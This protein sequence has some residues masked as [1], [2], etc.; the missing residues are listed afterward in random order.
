MNAHSATSALMPTVSLDELA[1]I[2]RCTPQTMTN[3]LPRLYDNGFPAKLPGERL[4]SRVAV[5]RWFSTNGE[6]WRPA[7]NDDDVAAATAQLEADYEN[8]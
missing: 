1:E 8:H 5:M 4:W 7:A 2:F 3:K 6:T